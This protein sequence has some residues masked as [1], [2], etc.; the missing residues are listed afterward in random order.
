MP[1]ERTS[2]RAAGKG[3]RASIIGMLKADHK[4]V[5]KAFRD[6]EKLDPQQDPEQCQAVVEQTLGDVQVHATLEEELFYPAARSCLSDQDLVDEAEVEHTTVK[7]LIE[8]LKNMGPQDDKYA[9]MFR[10]LGEYIDHHVKEEE[11]KLFPKLGR[12]TF[13]WDGLHDE[14]I[15]RRAE[16]E[17]EFLPHAASV[18]DE[19]MEGVD[20]RSETK[21]RPASAARAAR[22]LRGSRGEESMRAQAA[23][24]EDDEE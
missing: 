2:S 4:K 5:K 11:G 10:V 18:P 20:A 16:L 21:S 8:Q 9:A 7:V 6:F 17:Q 22:V 15:G 23:A 14:M 13:D 24:K 1:T 12:A 19:D 3:G